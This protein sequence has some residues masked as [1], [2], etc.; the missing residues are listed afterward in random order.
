MA[1]GKYEFQYL[2]FNLAWELQKV[3]TV[4]SLIQSSP[5]VNS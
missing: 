5:A 1:F 3:H 4:L 2:L